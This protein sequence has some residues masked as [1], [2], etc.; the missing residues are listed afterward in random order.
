[1]TRRGALA[2]VVVAAAGGGAW[3]LSGHEPGNISC[4]RVVE[5]APDYLDGVLAADLSEQI[6]AHLQACSKCETHL[7]QM[8]QQRDQVG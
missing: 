3:I 7:D 5:L 6:D 1:M 8:A 4:A 2:A